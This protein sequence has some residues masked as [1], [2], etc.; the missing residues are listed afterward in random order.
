MK[1]VFSR[2]LAA[3]PR[4]SLEQMSSTISSGWSAPLKAKSSSLPH[5][6][7]GH[8]R[9]IAF[10]DG[11]A[12]GERN[13]RKVPG[14]RVVKAFNTYTAS[15]RAA[16]RDNPGQTAMF[17]SGADAEANQIVGGLVQ[18]VDFEPADLGGWKTALLMDAPGRNGA[19]YGEA[20]TPSNARKIADLAARDIA[21]AMH[22]ATKTEK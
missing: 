7:T 17:I 1:C 8:S 20:H 16:A 13:Q 14:A 15:F 6:R 4:T 21:A 2:P 9:L 11:V 3:A 18:A 22:W 12:T 10:A 5:I 19:V